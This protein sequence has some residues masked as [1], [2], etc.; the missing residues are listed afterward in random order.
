MQQCKVKHV[1][2][3]KIRK[4]TIRVY[5]RFFRHKIEVGDLPLRTVDIRFLYASLFS[6]YRYYE[7]GILLYYVCAILSLLD[8]TVVGTTTAHILPMQLSIINTDHPTDY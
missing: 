4:Y 3:I 2:S 5:T 6:R 8:L 1:I 7:I